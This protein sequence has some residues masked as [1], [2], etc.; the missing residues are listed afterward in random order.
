[1]TRTFSTRGGASLL[2]ALLL[3]RAALAQTAANPSTTT[4][5]PVTELPPVTVTAAP[6]GSLTVPSLE[7]QRQA[8][9]AT[10]G[11]VEWINGESYRNSYANTL[12]DVL[13]TTPGV[14]VQ[15]RYGQEIRLSV[16]GSG[17]GRAF[18]LRGIELLQDGIPVNLADGSGDF[19][20][21]DPLA[22]RS[23][24][25]FKGGNGLVYGASSL[26]GA[27]NFVS[28]TAITAVA[29]NI[30]RLSVGSF[31]TVRSNGQVSRVIGDLDV[32]GNLTLTH[33]DGY[34]NHSRQN[35]L[36]FNANAGYRINPNVET[37]FYVGAYVV[38]QQLPGTLRLSQ[39]LTMPTM[40][41]PTA[42]RGNQS[43]ETWTERVANRTTVTLD[44]GKLDIDTWFI[45]KKL[46]HPIFQV[47][48]QDGIT[49]GIGPRYT[50]SFA[51]GGF[52]DDVIAGARFF[53]GNN[54][55]LQY[56]NLAGSRGAQTLNAR[57]N[58]RNYQ[59][60][61]E[62]RFYFLP[63]V[64]LMMGAKGF[65]DDRNYV[66]KGG[67]LASSVGYTNIDKTYSGF[68]PKIGLL[69]QPK[70]DIQAF[71]DLTRSLDV[72]DFSDL[73][74]TLAS[75]KTAFVPLAPQRAWTV[76]LGTRGR[77]DRYAWDV[78][79]YRS[80]LVGQLLNF[81]TV[82]NS[83]P[84]ST[85]NAGNTIIQGVELGASVELLRD[86]T[87]SGIG[88]KLTLS[89]LWNYTDAHF[90]NDRQYGDNKIAGL[91]PHV[92]RT[93]LT[94]THPSGFYVA[95]S[96]DFVPVGMYA[97]SAN[98]LQVPAYTLLNVQA[99]FDFRNGSLL[100]IDARNLADKRTIGDLGTISNARRVGTAVFYPG[101]GASI[102]AGARLAF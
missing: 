100:Y 87:G 80:S 71:V 17:I 48:D 35:A 5:T 3:A 16:R 102:Y 10:A 49:Y 95:P 74:Q 2:A 41:S 36:Q 97:D 91:P 19:Y 83:I 96:V 32:L 60:Y 12:R 44:V 29:P 26:G 27:I 40:A 38:A 22:Y 7:Q 72:P 58:A 34:R 18:H 28:P 101:E 65:V 76:E 21:L 92:L 68:N 1:M 64:A 56:V 9:D 51:L 25:V 42:V 89:Q 82:P 30:A 57:Q 73:T 53:A 66:D 94:Y 50:A 20:Q 79:L 55:A 54:T 98:T 15:N 37:R 14:Y 46:F 24:E 93:T 8:I 52:R 43:R 81:T 85:F 84:A 62:N 77:S 63:T 88:D 4:P 45:H 59:A 47:F 11:S 70:P 67:R 31:G 33:S 86:L 23:V 13:K 75:N 78:T 99:G 39:A 69:W 61:A 90:V 6:L